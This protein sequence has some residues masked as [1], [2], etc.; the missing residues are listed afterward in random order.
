MEKG[1]SS[2]NAEPYPHFMSK[3]LCST[4]MLMYLSKLWAVSTATHL[5]Y[6]H[7]WWMVHSNTPS[8]Q[9]LLVDGPQQH[10]F[11]TGTSGGWSTV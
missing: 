6:R 9:A 1:S 8:I 7:F 2:V 11:N 3:I 5:Q 4:W 10:T